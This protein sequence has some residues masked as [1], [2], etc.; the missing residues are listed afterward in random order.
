MGST[1]ARITC[2][3]PALVLQPRICVESTVDPVTLLRTTKSSSLL[4]T[5]LE[6]RSDS[7]FLGALHEQLR[8]APLSQPIA[9]GHL[10]AVMNN[11]TISLRRPAA[12]IGT[13]VLQAVIVEHTNE[14][15]EAALLVVLR[16][17]VSQDKPPEI[18]TA[19]IDA[20]PLDTSV[21]DDQCAAAKYLETWWQEYRVRD[22]TASPHGAPKSWLWLGDPSTS[23]YK[24]VPSSWEAQIRTIGSVLGMRTFIAKTVEEARAQAM[25]ERAELVI[26]LQGLRRWETFE[27]RA[28]SAGLDVMTV[29]EPGS[30]F[31]EL[32]E[33]TRGL[34]VPRILEPVNEDAFA[35]R[36]LAPGETIY[37]EKIGHN[38]RFDY[39]DAGSPS[40]CR[41]GASSFIP[42]SGDKA[43]KGMAR[44]YTNFGSNDV[45]ML[46]CSKHPNC[47]VYA[48]RRRSK[49]A[50]N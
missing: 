45:Q 31:E 34:L 18:T 12:E 41:H 43:T 35:S 7:A 6:R 33:R 23:G 16:A 47:G 20:Y 8:S 27:P 40:P 28:A 48:V 4:R 1:R 37:H 9:T 21:L 32:L 13:D 39:F 50:D 44:R 10:V 30:L 5:L 24:G 46:H 49:R 17:N 19:T 25:H 36:E 22:L 14:G 11:P 42:W 29:G 3:L 15:T 38:P 26:R 2:S